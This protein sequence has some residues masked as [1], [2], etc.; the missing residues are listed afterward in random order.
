M[1]RSIAVCSSSG[2]VVP[3][4]VLQRSQS[5]RS[6][7]RLD[8]G[9]PSFQALTR[10]NRPISFSHPGHF[11]TGRSSTFVTFS[12][13]S[14]MSPIPTVPYRVRQAGAFLKEAA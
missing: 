6:V 8:C 2:I 1:K 14:E 7:R 11:G 10:K 4:T 12:L 5:S 3:K 9:S 13:L